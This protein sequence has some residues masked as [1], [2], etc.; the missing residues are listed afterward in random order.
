M[1][2]LKGTLTGRNQHVFWGGAFAFHARFLPAEPTMAVITEARA[3][4]KGTSAS[5]AGFVAQI[6]ENHGAMLVFS[7]MSLLL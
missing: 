7:L 3:V 5:A 6:R 2:G 1:W 4:S